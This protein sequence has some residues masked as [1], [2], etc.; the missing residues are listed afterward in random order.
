MTVATT[1]GG[2]RTI[3][4]RRVCPRSLC[5]LVQSIA[6]E[7]LPE[8]REAQFTHLYNREDLVLGNNCV[9]NANARTQS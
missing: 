4:E 6:G 2:P 7:K 1:K 5:C 3:Q 9:S 8:L